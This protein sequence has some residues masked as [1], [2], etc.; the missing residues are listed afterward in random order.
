MLSLSGKGFHYCSGPACQLS[1]GDACDGNLS[2]AGASTKDIARPQN[3]NLSYGGKGIYACT[4]LNTVALTFD[5]GPYIYTSGLLD[6]LAHYNA[7]ATFFITGNNMGK[8]AID[9]VSTGYP[10]ILQRMYK[11]GHQIAHHTWTH[12]NFTAISEVQREN[13]MYFN[14]M[15]FRNVLGVFPTY[16][17]P[18][19]SSCNDACQSLMAKLGYHIVYYNLNTQG[20]SSLPPIPVPSFPSHLLH[21]FPTH[22][23]SSAFQSQLMNRSDYLYKD[24]TLIQTSKDLV[25]SYFHTVNGDRPANF[26]EIGHDVHNQTVHNLTAYILDRMA[27]LGFGTSVTVGECLGDPKEN[28][29]RKADG[30]PSGA[31]VFGDLVSGPYGIFSVW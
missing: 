15:A 6:I 10:Q 3:S 18:P 23:S 28:W 8:G 27:V 11:E 26:I 24:A 29:Y 25:D 16:V 17:R 31:P 30:A 21:L 9:N 19:Y 4:K 14:E 13:Q 1:Y 5:D 7:K 22:S 20:T 2:P 12:Q